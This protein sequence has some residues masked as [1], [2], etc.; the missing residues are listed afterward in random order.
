[1]LTRA[2]RNSSTG[3]RINLTENERLEEDVEN[4]QIQQNSTP[5]RGA[6]GEAGQVPSRWR[7]PPL[8]RHVSMVA[9]VVSR[10]HFHKVHLTSQLTRTELGPVS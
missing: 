3:V 10:V 2:T 6:G 5:E 1:V 9:S 4:I 7:L 8:D